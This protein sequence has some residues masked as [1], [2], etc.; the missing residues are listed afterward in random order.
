MSARAAALAGL[1]LTAPAFGE[2]NGAAAS[3]GA[4][5]V[6]LQVL[7]AGG[8]E[9]AGGRAGSGYLLWL[10]GRARVV[11]DFGPGAALRFRQS[12]ARASDLDLALFT[13]VRAE[14]TVDFPALVAAAL[15]EGRRRPLPLY[16]PPSSRSAPSTVT[17]ARTLLD[18]TRG[19][20]RH[21]GLVLNPLAR[22]GFKLQPHD[23]RP[24]ARRVGARRPAT[25]G[26]EI[27]RNER[28]QATALE[29]PGD[30]TRA[31]AWRIE[32]GGRSVV[33]AASGTADQGAI[34]RFA[35]NADLLVA[36]Y[37]PL[38]PD[39]AQKSTPLAQIGRLAAAADVKHLIVSE[40][41]RLP[42]QAAAAGGY[43]GVLAYADDLN[44]FPVP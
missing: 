23:A 28:V 15:R 37:R 13:R 44:C 5:G 11:V 19:A 26:W 43:G 2:T 20:Y 24:P 12:G 7:G 21:L 8:P 29:L 18:P 10:D 31:L 27:Y 34:A 35:R 38:S 32:G 3:C 36:E 16:G 9:L 4:D 40:R 1:L 22:D 30:G 6:Q 33:F 42:D 25:G 14:Q 17:F 41:Y 39:A